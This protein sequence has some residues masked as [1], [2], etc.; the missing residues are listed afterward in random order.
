MKKRPCKE[1]D[2]PKNATQTQIQVAKFPWQL[3]VQ[4][5]N[6]D[7]K[8][9]EKKKNTNTHRVYDRATGALAA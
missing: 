3:P 6:E 2:R 7:N 9:K 5:W 1:G 4:P 8:K